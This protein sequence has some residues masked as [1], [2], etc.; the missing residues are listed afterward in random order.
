MRKLN[1]KRS[2]AKVGWWVMLGDVFIVCLPTRKEA[3]SKAESMSR[4]YGLEVS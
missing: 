2:P 4:S 1:V 3:Y